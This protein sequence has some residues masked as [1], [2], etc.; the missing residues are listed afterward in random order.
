MKVLMSIKPEFANKIFSGEKKFEFRRA[1]FKNKNIDTIVVYASH[2]VMK[3]I[4]EFKI[5][6]IHHKDIEDLWNDTKENSGIEK[7]FFIRYFSGKDKG[8][9]IEIKDPIL[10]D[11]PLCIKKDLN[12]TPPQSF[13]YI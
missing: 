8:F 11:K 10:Y 9:A 2:P 12:K 13:C 7:S 3:V 1:I 6:E 4:G 5:K